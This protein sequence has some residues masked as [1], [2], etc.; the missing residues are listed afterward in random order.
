MVSLFGSV[1]GG[2]RRWLDLG[3]FN[4]QP[5]ETFKIILIFL[6][7]RIL[8]TK[9]S[10][11][12]M[13]TMELIKPLCLILF[14]VLF[15]IFQPDLGT[16][17]ITLIITSSIIVFAKVHKNILF[18]SILFILSISPIAWNFVLK[19]YQKNRILTFISPGRDPRGTGYNTIQSKIA[20]G[21]GQF[22]GK[23]F[24]KGTQSQ[25][26]FLPERHT[27]FIFSVLSE[28]HGFIGSVVT[29]LL[30]F[31]FNYHWDFIPHSN[32]KTR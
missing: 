7:A 18:F 11:R 14:P 12:A 29:I 21:S 17:L 23:G 10:W 20:I 3:L 32:P 26:E 19:D 1:F 16:A 4:Y 6:L 30:F 22:L 9:R 25:L 31:I 27:D 28:E 13:T 5:S 8:S 15:I 2:S 24:Q